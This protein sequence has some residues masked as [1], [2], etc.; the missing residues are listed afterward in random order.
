MDY[1][2]ELQKRNNIFQDVSDNHIDEM[3][4]I[5]RLLIETIEKGNKVMTAGN[6]GSAANAQHITGDIVGR[7]KLERTAY[8]AVSLTVDSS[9]TTAIANDY[10]YEEVF[11]RQLEGIGNAN[12]VLVVL[13]ASA[14][15]ENLLRAVEQAEK[16]G[17]TTVGV[18]GNNGG[19]LKE[20]VDISIAFDFNESDLV[21]ET[22]MAIFHIILM[23]VEVELT[24]KEGEKLK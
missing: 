22:A 15:S 1:T 8:P 17:I 6:G 2:T 5:T 3:K 18:L 13:S 9:L 24:K 12:D 20:K 19:T 14:T 21:E 16:M 10:G 7:Y 23:E 4:A 11:A